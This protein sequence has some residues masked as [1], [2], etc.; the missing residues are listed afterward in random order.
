MKS[1]TNVFRHWAP[2]ISAT[3]SRY[4]RDDRANIAILFGL[5]APVLIGALGLGMETSWWYQTQRDMQNAADEAAIAAATDATSSYDSGA[6]PGTG[7][8]GSSN[9]ATHT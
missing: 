9:G 6:Q 3:L 8:Y 4:R 5:L 2:K 7:N 1:I